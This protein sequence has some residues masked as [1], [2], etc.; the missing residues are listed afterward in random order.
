M[1]AT[2]STTLPTV[3]MALKKP[4][5]FVLNCLMAICAAAAHRPRGLDAV[6]IEATAVLLPPL[7]TRSV[8]AVV[9]W[10]PGDSNPPS[11]PR[12]SVRL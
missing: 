7:V 6:V 5:P 3:W 8:D 10:L 4:P 12:Q 2:A 9:Y 11:R 1:P